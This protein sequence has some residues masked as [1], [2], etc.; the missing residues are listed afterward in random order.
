MSPRSP[1]GHHQHSQLGLKGSEAEPQVDDD[2]GEAGVD[3]ESSFDDSD[4]ES[5]QDEELIQ[6]G[7]PAHSGELARHKKNDLLSQS[8]GLESE[9]T[10][11]STAAAG[12]V[13]RSS[14]QM[15]RRGGV[16]LKHCRLGVV[17]KRFVWC[18]EALENIYWTSFKRRPD[19]SKRTGAKFKARRL[20]L[21]ELLAVETGLDKFANM[22]P[23]RGPIAW[24]LRRTRFSSSS[25]DTAALKNMCFTLAFGK[26]SLDLE[27]DS[28]QQRSLWVD[29]FRQLLAG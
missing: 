2:A 15:L 13:G 7:L 21:S 16:F 28:P 10:L 11:H 22:K 27:T 18:D 19:E 3:S 12:R 23:G 5:K 14:Y 1:R 8:D 17:R 26:R 6:D 4:E 24:V 29:A 20:P 25:E 9:I